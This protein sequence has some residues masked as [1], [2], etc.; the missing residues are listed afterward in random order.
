MKP[1]VLPAAALVFVLVMADQVGADD[2]HP[3]GTLVFSVKTWQ[4]DYTSKDIPGGVETT[5]VEGAIYTVK[6]DGTGL[7]KIVDLGKNTDFPTYSPDGRWVYFQS[8]AS[9]RSHVYRCTPEGKE[10]AI[11]TG[12]DRLGKPWKGAY[13]YALSRDGRRLLYTVHDGESGRVVLAN[14]DGGNPSVLFPKRGY[15]YMGALSPAGDRVVVSGPAR[16]YRLLIAG[17]PHGE[18]RELTPDHPESFVPQFTPDGKTV[19]FLRRDGDIYRVDCD[20]K[21]LRRLTEGNQHVEFRLS[22]KDCARLV[23]RPPRLTGR[24]ADCLHCGQGRCRQCLRDADRWQQTAPGYQAQGGMWPGPLG[25]RRQIPGLR[26]IREEISA[27]L[28]G[29]GR[30]WRT[31]TGHAPGWGCELRQ[32]ETAGV[33]AHENNSYDPKDVFQST[34]PYSS[35]GLSAPDGWPVQRSATTPIKC[36]SVRNA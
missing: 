18:P 32:L 24:P 20:G 26:V 28:H 19:V 35:S 13:G 9:G 36:A 4:G 21:N 27:A 31:A 29:R 33:S 3:A 14:A 15:T 6:G 2:K 11:L 7:Q 1:S 25:S 30:R 34:V 22:A 12:A 17:L 10:V 8:N 5:P 16:G 23:R